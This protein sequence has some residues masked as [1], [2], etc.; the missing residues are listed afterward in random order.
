MRPTPAFQRTWFA[1]R[2]LTP[3]VERFRSGRR[4]AP[5]FDLECA[6]DHLDGSVNAIGAGFLAGERTWEFDALIPPRLA[7]AARLEGVLDALDLPPEGKRPYRE[8]LSAVREVLHAISEA[9]RARGDAQ[10][11]V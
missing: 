3:P 4:N 10:E 8:F 7:E 2:R 11:A 6:L 9:A 5:T 1:W